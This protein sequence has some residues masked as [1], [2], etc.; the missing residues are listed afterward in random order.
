MKKLEKFKSTQRH[1]NKFSNYL[2]IRARELNLSHTQI[3]QKSSIARQTWYRLLN[4]EVEEA[5]LSTL[6]SVSKVLRVDVLDLI[7]MHIN[8]SPYIGK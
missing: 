1:N 2:R 7:Q 6:I 4:S 8:S 5:K 3:A